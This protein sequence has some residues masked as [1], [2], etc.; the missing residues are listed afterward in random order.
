MDKTIVSIL[1]ATVVIL[2]VAIFVSSQQTSS[3]PIVAVDDTNRPI[4]MVSETHFNFG[5]VQ[6]SDE[7]VRQVTIRN[8]GQTPLRLGKVSTSCDCTFATITMPSGTTSPEFSMHG[9][10]SWQDEL[11]TGET[12]TI[13]VIYRPAVMPV[14]GKVSRALSITTNDPNQPSIQIA[15]DAEVE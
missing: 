6:M 3:K 15:F 11:K 14:K 9:M 13:N 5:T 7:P 8:E 1:G 12:A 2:G 4:A 10:N